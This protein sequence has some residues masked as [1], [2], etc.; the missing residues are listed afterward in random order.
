MAMRILYGVVGEGMGHAMRSRVILDELVKRHEVQVVVSGRAYDYLKARAGEHLAVKK[1]WGYSIVYEDNE[2]QNFKTLLQNVKGAVTGWP[3][4]VRAYFDVAEK[5]QPD[6]VI[7]DIGLPGTLD[8][9]A[10]A[11]TLRG[12]PA[13]AGVRLIAISG[14]A[15]EDARRRSRDAG[16]DAH[17]AKPPDVA[18]LERALG[19][20]R[21]G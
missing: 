3:K 19:D 8:G 14:Y 7:S 4:N 16:F 21:R 13:H 18:T 15:N 2:V 9:Y 6:V 1:I 11:R 10:V 20:E 17:I 5:F 12:D